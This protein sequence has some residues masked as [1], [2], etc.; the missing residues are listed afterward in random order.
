VPQAKRNI[1][2]AVEAVARRLGNTQAVC[3][4]CYVHPAVFDAY[5]D[6]TLVDR[7]R[8]LDQPVRSLRS[9]DPEEAEVLAIM[10][11]RPRKHASRG[12][13]DK[14]ARHQKR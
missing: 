1:V 8:V 4:K 12:N 3:R 2:R 6:G 10:H 9:L 13:A 7:V 14:P 5:L 11:V